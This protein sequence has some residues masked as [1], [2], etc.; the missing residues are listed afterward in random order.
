MQNTLIIAIMYSN[1]ETYE[2]VKSIL[3]KKFNKIEKLSNE[4]EKGLEKSETSQ[5]EKIK[6]L[7]ETLQRLQAEFENYKK[8]IDKEKGEFVKYSKHEVI[9]KILPILDSFELAIKNAKNNPNFLKGVELIFSQLYS[10]LESEGLRPI[11]ALGKKFDP[12]KHEV[13]MQE[14]SDKEEDVV[15]EELQKGYMLNDKVLRHSKVKVSKK[16]LK[17][18]VSK[19]FE[20]SKTFQNKEEKKK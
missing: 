4:S 18:E 17:S 5:K 14:A 8:R 12:Y 10:T 6:E 9:A 2:K 15:L 20:K 3:I 7:T 13:L 19:G 11:E 1:K 16:L